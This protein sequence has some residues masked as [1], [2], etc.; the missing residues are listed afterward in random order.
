MNIL[1]FDTIPTTRILIPCIFF[2][3]YNGKRNRYLYTKVIEKQVRKIA[4]DCKL[5]FYT[6]KSGVKN[7]LMM[8]SLIE[9]LL[10]NQ[11]SEWQQKQEESM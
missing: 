5:L 1:L 7:D 3:L 9:R 2:F 10:S 6:N 8:F 4:D 11:Q